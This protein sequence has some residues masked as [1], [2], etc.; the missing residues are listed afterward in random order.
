M[1]IA[2]QGIY[3][4]SEYFN[5]GTYTYNGP[6]SYSVPSYIFPSSHGFEYQKIKMKSQVQAPV[7]SGLG[8]G[9]LGEGG[10][11]GGLVSTVDLTYIKY[12]N[13]KN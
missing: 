7:S 4:N 12:K 2:W 1:I 9:G 13:K 8:E 11:G 5:A 10:L 3:N 6:L